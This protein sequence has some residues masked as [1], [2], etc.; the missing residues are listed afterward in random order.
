MEGGEKIFK[1]VHSMKFLT[2]GVKEKI[3]EFYREETIE[4][5]LQRME[6]QKGSSQGRHW[7]LEG[8]GKYLQ[9]TD[10]K[11]FSS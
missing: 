8:I 2:V 4:L 10:R 1:Q 7:M 6:Y 11:L 3:L 9:N 5:T